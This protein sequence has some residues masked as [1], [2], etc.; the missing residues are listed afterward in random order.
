MF[1]IIT[2]FFLRDNIKNIFEYIQISLFYVISL[3]FYAYTL[4]HSESQVQ[5]ITLSALWINFMF[6]QLLALAQLYQADEADGL[7]DQWRVLPYPFEAVIAAKLVAQ[8]L[9]LTLPLLVAVPVLVFMLGTPLGEGLQTA[10]ALAA[11]SFSMLAIGSLGA[12]LA[13]EKRRQMAFLLLVIMPLYLPVLLLGI[14]A[15]QPENPHHFEAWL[16]LIGM[17]ALTVPL[18][19]IATRLLLKE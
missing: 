10:A 9:I 12:A 16:G 18:S 8:W 5:D 13:A 2:G 4:T 17:A 7:L 11:A 15:S 19:V 3:C 1:W 6:V 14:T